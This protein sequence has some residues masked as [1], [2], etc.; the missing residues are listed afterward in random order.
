[1]KNNLI[2]NLIGIKTEEMHYIGCIWG[3]GE[4]QSENLPLGYVLIFQKYYCNIF[5]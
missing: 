4:L 2:Y 3:G 1:M 5:H